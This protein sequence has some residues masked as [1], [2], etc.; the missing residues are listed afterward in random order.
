MKIPYPKTPG[1]ILVNVIRE[2]PKTGLFKGIFG[3]SASKNSTK[4]YLSSVLSD[5]ILQLNRTSHR[6]TVYN[7]IVHLMTNKKV[8][9][10]YTDGHIERLELADFSDKLSS[11]QAVSMLEDFAVRIGCQEIAHHSKVTCRVVIPKARMS[12]KNN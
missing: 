5:Y 8:K 2:V 12:K 3:S 11:A 6:N 9:I 4:L 1:D 7:I 10:V